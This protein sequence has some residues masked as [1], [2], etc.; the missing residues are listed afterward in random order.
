[1]GWYCFLCLK[2]RI[3]PEYLEFV[4]K[5]YFETFGKEHEIYDDELDNND[6]DKLY[7]TLPKH[8]KNIIDIWT[9]LDLNGWMSQS[10]TEDG[11]YKYHIEKK[12]NRHKDGY[13]DLNTDMETFLKDIIVQMTS[14]I[15]ECSISDD[16]YMNNKVIYTDADLR[17]IPF[18]LVDKIKSVQHVYNEDRTEILETRIVYK[19]S[20]PKIQFID[21]KRALTGKS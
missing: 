14:E 17:N 18:R 20:V 12:V 16:D 8:Y 3:R 13:H 19:H 7:K 9:K 6:G 15:Y 1:M 2:C 5:E 4:E 11:L 10:R 21:L